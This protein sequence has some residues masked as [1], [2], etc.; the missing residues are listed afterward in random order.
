MNVGLPRAVQSIVMR[1]QT[2]Q[3]Q[4]MQSPVLTPAPTPAPRCVECGD[5]LDD[6]SSG[7]GLCPHCAHDDFS[8]PAHTD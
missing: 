7:A 2:E 6:R 4:L 1:A 3:Q 5:V 8:L